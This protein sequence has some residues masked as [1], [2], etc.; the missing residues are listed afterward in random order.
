MEEIFKDVPGYEGRYQV[1]NFGNV[2]SLNYNHTGKTKTLSAGIGSSGYYYVMLFNGKKGKTLAVHQLVAMAF[3][4][5][6]TCGYKLVV[7][8]IDHNRINNRVDN[9]EIVTNRCNLNW[10]KNK[11]YSNYPGVS[12]HKTKLKYQARIYAN[13]KSKH[14]GTFKNEDEAGAAYQKALR[15]LTPK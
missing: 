13:G 11:G 9:L 3:L 1:S 4:N 10:R 6:T 2:L 14:L 15:E 5:H 8:H 7:N 12:W